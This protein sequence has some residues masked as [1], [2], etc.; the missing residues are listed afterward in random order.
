MPR[1]EKR[2]HKGTGV[3]PGDLTHLF[4]VIRLEFRV[5]LSLIEQLHFI[6]SD[7]N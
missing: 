4:A 2:L 7:L 1:E 3:G 6:S 5:L